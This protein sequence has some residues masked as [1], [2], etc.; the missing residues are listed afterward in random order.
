[1]TSKNISENKEK[2]RERPSRSSHYQE[3][4]CE[5]K[6]D[7][8]VWSS[9]LAEEEDEEV[10]QELMFRIRKRMLS[11]VWRTARAILPEKKMIILKKYYEDGEIQADIGKFFSRNRSTVVKHNQDSL[12]K[13]RSYLS[14]SPEWKELCSLFLAIQNGENVSLPKEKRKYVLLSLSE[15]KKIKKEYETGEIT[16]TALAEKYGVSRSAISAMVGKSKNGHRNKLLARRDYSA[17]IPEI[18]QAREEGMFWKD[19][20]TKFKIGAGKLGEILRGDLR[21]PS[22]PSETE[23]QERDNENK[24]NKRSSGDP[25]EERL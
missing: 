21:L 23:K 6:V 1:M 9:F 17:L 5:T 14:E 15:K 8:F 20:Q 25:E 24:Y 7:D 3:I 18:L 19:M 13:L 2:A 10:D 22:E 16:S 11:F 4:F 12:K